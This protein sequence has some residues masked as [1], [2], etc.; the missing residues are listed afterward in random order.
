MTRARDL[1]DSADKDISGT[2][3][4][5][6]IVLSNDLTVADNGKAIF[7]ASSD[8]QIYHSTADAASIITDQGTGPLAIQ[9]NFIL[10]QNSGGTAN[11]LKA[12][13]GGAVE[14][15]HSNAVKLATTATGVDVTGNVTVSALVTTSGRFI[16]ATDSYDPWLKGINS[17]GTETSFIKKDGQGYFGGSVGIGTSSP[18]EK[19]VLANSS[20]EIKFGLDGSS[21]DIFSNGKTF[22]IGTTDDTVVRMF[23]NNSET[24]RLSGGNVGIGSTLT[25]RGLLN[26][27]HVNNGHFFADPHIALT[28]TSATDNASS[29]GITYATSDSDNYGYF[30]GAQ[31]TNGGLGNFILKWHDNSSGGTREVFRVDS[32]SNFLVGTTNS[33]VAIQSTDVGAVITSTGR[34]FT[35]SADHHGFN[36]TSNG[37]VIRFRRSATEVGNISVTSSATSFNTSSDYRLKENVADLTGATTRLKQ[38]EPKRFNFIADADTTVDGFLAHEVQSVVPEAI[39]GTHNEVDDDGNPV[40][41]GIDQSKLVPLLVATIKELEARITA[42]EGA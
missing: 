6:D 22:N 40:Y 34:I 16:N 1:A 30:L 24:M 14:L 26:V 29:A 12:T 18:S 39:T 28:L 13:E 8:L 20:N 3:T 31:R 33:S 27:N 42:L 4:L 32:D 21:H 5:D 25:D 35:T 23:Q 11:L 38:L 15:L 19:L 17:S 36:R 2:L 41:Q 10:L 9:S 7:G 37:E